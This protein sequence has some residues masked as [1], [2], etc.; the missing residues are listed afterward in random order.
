MYPI[1]A[2]PILQRLFVVTLLQFRAE[3]GVAPTYADVLASRDVV[4][5]NSVQRRQVRLC[6]VHILLP[7]V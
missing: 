7:S 6:A 4:L 3:R 1:T 2:E 5:K